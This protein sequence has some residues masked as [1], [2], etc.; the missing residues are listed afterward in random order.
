MEREER[1]IRLAV[2]GYIY[3]VARDENRHQHG[4]LWSETHNFTSAEQSPALGLPLSSPALCSGLAW[5]AAHL[6]FRHHVRIRV[7]VISDWC[8]KSKVVDRGRENRSYLYV[9][10][11]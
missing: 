2:P 3:P 5:C 7:I 11:R 10:M 4:T 9:L 8:G 6:G 1:P